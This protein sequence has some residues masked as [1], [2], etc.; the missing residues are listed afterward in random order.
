M[1]KSKVGKY[2]YREKKEATVV[3]KSLKERKNDRT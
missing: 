2:I 1:K 3:K